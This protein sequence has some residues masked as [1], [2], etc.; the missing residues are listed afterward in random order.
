DVTVC[1][2]YEL[3]ADPELRLLCVSYAVN[4]EP[5]RTWNCSF[6]GGDPEAHEPVPD[7]LLA[8]LEDPDRKLV[9]WNAAFERLTLNAVRKRYGLPFIPVEKT[10]C[11]AAWARAHNLPG[12]LGTCTKEWLP[13]DK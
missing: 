8:A 12:A 1:G 5:V 9:A 4:D 11:A 10:I 3:A 13:A 7:D 2:A 6:A